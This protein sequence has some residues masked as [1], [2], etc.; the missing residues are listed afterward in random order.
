MKARTK[1]SHGG[2]QTIKMKAWR[3]KMM[4]RRVCMQVV[5]DVHHCGEQQDPDLHQSYCSDL[6]PHQCEMSVPQYCFTSHRKAS[7]I[8]ICLCFLVTLSYLGDLSWLC[9]VNRTV[10]KP[11]AFSNFKCQRTKKSFNY[12][13][14]LESI[15]ILPVTVPAS[16]VER[17]DGCLY[18]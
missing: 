16:I 12:M 18:K 17:E 4:P 13:E 11:V 10:K 6:D 14:D 2:M 8:S 15:C 5:A 3:L 1:W 7:G 9:T